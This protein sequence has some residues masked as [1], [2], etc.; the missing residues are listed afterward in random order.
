MGLETRKSKASSRPAFFNWSWSVAE[1]TALK[2]SMRA[3]R[4]G[5]TGEGGFSRSSPATPRDASSARLFDASLRK[6]MWLVRSSLRA[7]FQIVGTVVKLKIVVLALFGAPLEH[8]IA[9]ALKPR[10]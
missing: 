2:P 8:Q 5:N 1:S 7:R 6:P 3:N 10:K 9:H 4:P